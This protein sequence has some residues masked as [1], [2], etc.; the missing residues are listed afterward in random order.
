MLLLLTNQSL[1]WN[2]LG[3]RLIT[4]IAYDQLTHHAKMR[5]N[6]DNRAFSD[7]YSRSLVIASVWLDAIRFKT[8]AYDAMH[9]SDIPFSDDGSPLPV[10]PEINAVQAVE[11]ASQTLLNP[12]ASQH[13]KS[14]A[15]RILIHVVADLHQPLHAATRVSRSF[16]EG[17]RGG[18]EV[19]LRKN[20]IAN[21]LHAFWDRGAGLLVGRRRYGQAWV[22]HR[23]KQIEQR[24]PCDEISHL[25]ELNPKYWAAESH[26]LAKHAYALMPV[27]ASYQRRAIQLLEPRFALAGCRLARVLNHIDSVLM[28][29]T[30]QS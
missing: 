7:D 29:E 28:N 9:Y 5:F 25:G 18:N 15:L 3:H 10:L 8:H 6:R 26:E 11:H 12:K 30:N 17:D 20:P 21:T 22:K 23:A 24:W 14:V 4:Q 2:A 1:A 27:D 19:R 13:A 16:P